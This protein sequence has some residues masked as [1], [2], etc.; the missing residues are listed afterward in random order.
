MQIS[1]GI[2]QEEVIYTVP[3]ASESIFGLYVIIVKKDDKG[4]TA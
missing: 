1:Y 4:E 3:K 2:L